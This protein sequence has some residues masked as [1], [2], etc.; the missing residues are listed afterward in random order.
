MTR[1]AWSAVIAYSVPAAG[2]GF[3]FL[4]MTLYVVKYATDVLLIA[5]AAIGV[6]FGLTRIWDAVL[7]PFAG[8]LSDRTLSRLGRRRS[9][10]LLSAIPLALTF[11]ALFNP[12]RGLGGFGLTAWVGLALL[13]YSSLHSVFAVPHE[14]LGA[15]LTLDHH[16]RTRLFGAKH[17]VQSLG[18]LAAAIAVQALQ[19]SDAPRDLAW[20]VVGG[21]ALATAVLIL[22]SV[23]RLR[24]PAAHQG[25][26]G[27]DVRRAFAD[28]LR[29][30]HARLLLAVFAIESLGSASIGILSPYVAQYIV[31]QKEVLLP[32]LLGFFIPNLLLPPVFIALSRRV[33]KKQLWLAAMAVMWIGYGGL[34]FLGEGDGWL[35]IL[36]GTIAGSG[37]CCANVVGPS[38]K[39]DVI[40]FDEMQTG[41]RKEGAYFAVWNFVRK[42]ATGIAAMLTGFGLQLAGFAP[43]AEQSDAARWTILGFYGGLPAVCYLIGTLLFARFSLDGAEHARIRA[44]LDARSPGP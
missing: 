16:E 44:A 22:A 35:M 4:L 43:N 1:L 10:M 7:D 40:D 25:R 21:G 37:S 30:P 27:V 23:P 28:V 3:G 8:H 26:G 5:P 20:A 39:A 31:G 13:L 2:V 12:P 24:E 11:F 18:M 33:G 41:Q 15:E 34:L 32:A 6:L 38:V 29:N 9:W 36:L 14:A 42:G 19:V 17:L